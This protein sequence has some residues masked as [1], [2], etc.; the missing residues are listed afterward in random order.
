MEQ[1][2]LRLTFRGD[3]HQIDTNTLIAEL[4]HITTVINQVNAEI[5]K[6]SRA[7]NTNVTAIEKKRQQFAFTPFAINV[8][9][10][11]IMLR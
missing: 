8:E 6:G 9:R 1:N 3:S 5:G 11:T 10:E 4:T 2:A 7:I